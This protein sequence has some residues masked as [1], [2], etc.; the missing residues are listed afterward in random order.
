M[1]S[2]SAADLYALA[3]AWGMGRPAVGQGDG[4]HRLQLPD[5]NFQTA[6]LQ[7]VLWHEMNYQMAEMLA[8]FMK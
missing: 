6:S 1:T 2:C 7:P 4:W 5:E 3:T 8:I